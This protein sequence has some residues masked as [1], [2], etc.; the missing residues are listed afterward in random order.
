[1]NLVRARRYYDRALSIR[2]SSAATATAEDQLPPALRALTMY[3]HWLTGAE[4]HGNVVTSALK[5]ALN[6]LSSAVVKVESLN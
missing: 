3:L 5:R 1:M 6:C 4:E 2:D